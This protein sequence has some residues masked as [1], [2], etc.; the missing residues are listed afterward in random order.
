MSLCGPGGKICDSALR[1]AA[2]SAIFLLVKSDLEAEWGRPISV[3][4]VL[5]AVVA[6]WMEWGRAEEGGL[7]DPT[8]EVL[9]TGAS[10]LATEAFMSNASKDA[11]KTIMIAMLDRAWLE[12]AAQNSRQP[13]EPVS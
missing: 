13:G 2:L 9:L 1:D 11:A 8:Q 5:V 10:M 7:A 12:V 4:D 3:A 6:A